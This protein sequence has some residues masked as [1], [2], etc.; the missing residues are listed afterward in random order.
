MSGATLLQIEARREGDELVLSVRDDGPGPGSSRAKGVGLGLPTRGSGWRHST[1]TGA[2]ELRRG[3]GGRHRGDGAAA[4]A[5]PE[6]GPMQAEIRALIV[7]DEPLARRG[8]RQ[9]LRAPPRRRRGRRVP[10]T[11]ARRCGRSRRSTPDLV[12]LDVQMPGLDGF[13]VIAR[14]SAP[15][16]CRRW[17]S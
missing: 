17:S 2:L 13:D 8:I 11:G 1:G 3:A 10:A 5:P 7:D 6:H 15:S 9:L 12:F 14:P 16:A 4:L